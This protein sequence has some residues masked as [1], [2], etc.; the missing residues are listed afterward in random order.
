MTRPFPCVCPRLQQSKRERH[1]RNVGKQSQYTLARF[2][3]SLKHVPLP[4]KSMLTPSSWPTTT[5]TRL[6]Y[7]A[8]ALPRQDASFCALSH[9]RGCQERRPHSGPSRITSLRATLNA[10]FFAGKFWRYHWKT[11]HCEVDWRSDVS[12]LANDLSS[13]QLASVLAAQ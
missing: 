7:Y 9:T 11:I 6:W 13:I 1:Q 3:R 10:A 2:H 12:W 4:V 5:S 8:W